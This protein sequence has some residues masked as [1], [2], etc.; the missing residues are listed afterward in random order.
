MAN[1]ILQKD[2]NN[3]YAQFILARNEA[4][5]DLKIDKLRAV[6]QKFP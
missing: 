1:T 2:A 3:M 4:N 5:V 6:T